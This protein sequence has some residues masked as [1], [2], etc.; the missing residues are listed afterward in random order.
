[1]GQNKKSE[2]IGMEKTSR[3]GKKAKVI[4][5]YSCEN[6]M[7]EFENGLQRKLT[8]WHYFENEKFNYQYMFHKVRTSGRVGTKLRMNNGMTAVVNLYRNC[9]DMDIRFEDGEIASH[10]SWRDFKNGNVAHPILKGTQISI[11]ELTLAFYLEPLGFHKIPQKSTESFELGLNGKELDFYDP[12]HKIA[13]EYDGEYVH[14]TS[15]N[16]LEKN[17]LLMNL[18]ITLYR[19]REPKCSDITGNCYIL[20]ET[21]AFS[22]SLERALQQFVCHILNEDEKKIDFQKDIEEIKKFIRKRKR[23]NLHLFEQNVMSN[24]MVGTII[25]MRSC[26]D[27][28]VKFEDGAIAY[29]K[30]Y[31]SF[32]EGSIAH[33]NATSAAKKEQRLYQSKIMNNG[34]MATVIEYRGWKNNT[35]E[36]DNG[37]KVYHVKWENF[38]CGKVGLPSSYIKNHIGERQLQKRGAVA[39]IISCRDANHID[40]RFEDGIIIRNR[41]YND[42]KKGVIGHPKLAPVRNRK[43]KERLGEI[44]K[45]NDGTVGK[46]IS[47]KNAGDIDVDFGENRIARHKA[48]ANFVSGKIRCPRNNHE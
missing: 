22:K 41:K 28:V 16:D 46:I 30:C 10:V 14:K 31:G 43:E 45:M 33:P 20:E 48:Y 29:N 24:G 13:V 40:V 34:H 35:V 8:N 2:R 32:K 1:M 19:F 44:R 37:E 23:S 18:G 5:Y 42:F 7:I 9:H 26:Q 27:I 25:A 6:F 11:N 15:E 38:E 36:F 4:E 3:D 39:E 21:K 12:E 47:Y 17:M